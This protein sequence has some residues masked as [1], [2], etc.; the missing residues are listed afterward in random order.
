M[1]LAVEGSHGVLGKTSTTGPP[2]D[3]GFQKIGEFLGARLE[4]SLPDR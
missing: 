1:A 2:A 4:F 3:K